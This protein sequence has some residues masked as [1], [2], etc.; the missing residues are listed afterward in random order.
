MENPGSEIEMKNLISKP[1]EDGLEERSLDDTSVSSTNQLVPNDNEQSTQEQS[2]LLS[3]EME[4]LEIDNNEN[5]ERVNSFV[6]GLSHIINSGASILEAVTNNEVTP[7][8]R[9][10]LLGLNDRVKE[11]DQAIKDLDVELTK[12]F[13][14]GHEIGNNVSEILKT[15]LYNDHIVSLKDFYKE[16]LNITLE[17]FVETVAYD[18]IMDDQSP[19]PP[20]IDEAVTK[21]FKKANEVKTNWE[22]EQQTT[23]GTSQ[24]EVH[25]RSV[26]EIPNSSSRNSQPIEPIP[27]KNVEELKAYAEKTLINKIVSDYLRSQ[28]DSMNIPDINLNGLRLDVNEMISSSIIEEKQGEKS[29]ANAYNIAHEINKP[30]RD[31]FI[32]KVKENSTLFPDY[33]SLKPE[34]K[35]ELMKNFYS[36][37]VELTINSAADQME[38]HTLGQYT[39]K[40]SGHINAPVDPLANPGEGLNPSP[41]VANNNLD[42]D[43]RQSL[44]AGTD[45]LAAFGVPNNDERQS[46]MAGTD[47]LAAFGVPNNAAPNNA[48]KKDSVI[49]QLMNKPPTKENT[50]RTKTI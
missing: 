16:K 45:D 48:A 9:T 3:R 12:G 39:Y 42:N 25:Q 8:L 30:T 31:H 36:R 18:L 1:S 24:E 28:T 20:T 6:Q 22:T 38:D 14:L 33:G 17:D 49:S 10:T 32:E 13:K 21:G 47:D 29:A 5:Q 37:D 41:E 44:M 19:N 7:V 27:F 4:P 43:E 26:L 40:V 23:N 11:I 2:S 50:T 15:A 46:L 35:L 34:Q